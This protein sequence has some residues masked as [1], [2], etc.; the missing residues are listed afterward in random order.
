MAPFNSLGLALRPG[1]D[2]VREVI[3]DAKPVRNDAPNTQ[4]G[5]TTLYIYY[6]HVV[7]AG[8]SYPSHKFEVHGARRRPG[9]T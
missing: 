3:T 5:W 8:D 7:A 2:V 1:D 6:R 9:L 4:A